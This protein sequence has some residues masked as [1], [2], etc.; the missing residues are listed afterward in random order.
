LQQVLANWSRT[1][2]A[3]LSGLLRKF[4]DDF[5]TYRSQSGVPATAHVPPTG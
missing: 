4:N 1:E 3:E 2:V 5:E